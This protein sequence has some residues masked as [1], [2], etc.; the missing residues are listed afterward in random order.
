MIWDWYLIHNKRLLKDWTSFPTSNAWLFA[1]G[2]PI[3]TVCA[4]IKEWPCKSSSPH[5][6]KRP[7][8]MPRSSAGKLHQ[9]S[10]IA[11]VNRIW[12]ERNFEAITARFLW[13][14]NLAWRLHGIKTVL[15]SRSS[16]KMHLTLSWLDTASTRH[17]FFLTPSYL[18][19]S[20]NCHF[21]FCKRGGQISIDISEIWKPNGAIPCIGFSSL[22]FKSSV[23]LSLRTSWPFDRII[24]NRW[25]PKFMWYHAFGPGPKA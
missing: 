10:R 22:V 21:R 11:R 14:K 17:L 2:R 5:F 4:G 1:T 9:S 13:R 6:P 24:P 8:A 16:S 25:T 15:T 20:A 7:T 3:S 23:K 12:L 19:A 18:S